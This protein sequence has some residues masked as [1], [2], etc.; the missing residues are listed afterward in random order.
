MPQAST[1]VATQLPLLRKAVVDEIEE[2]AIDR[3]RSTEQWW[4][5]LPYHVGQ[6]YFDREHGQIS[7]IPLFLDLLQL[8]G[9]AGLAEL[10]KS[11]CWDCWI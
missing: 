2:M 9:M 8:V 6:V 1:D 4:K 11:N 3:A 5:A 7:Q 10:T